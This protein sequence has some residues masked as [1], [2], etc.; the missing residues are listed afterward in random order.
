M[1]YTDDEL[2]KLNPNSKN[3]DTKSLQ[4]E[5]SNRGY[6]MWSSR[7]KTGFDG[8]YGN[9]TKSAL[10]AYQK[11]TPAFEYNAFKYEKGNKKM[12]GGKLLPSINKL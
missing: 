6:D 7:N 2:S 5:L 3:F 10:E 1:N 11:G 9:D 4:E 12:Y 8:I